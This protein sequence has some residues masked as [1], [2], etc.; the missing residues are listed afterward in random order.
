MVDE[1]GRP[2][3]VTSQRYQDMLQQCIG[4]QSKISGAFGVTGLM[5]IEQRLTQATSSST[6]SLTNFKEE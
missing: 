6:F 2:Q 4:L 3:S 1:N 5:E